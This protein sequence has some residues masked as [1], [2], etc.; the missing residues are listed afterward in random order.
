MLVGVCIADVALGK[1][2]KQECVC[3]CVWQW[4]GEIEVR[5]VDE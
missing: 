1:K 5:V 2:E 4:W 3:V